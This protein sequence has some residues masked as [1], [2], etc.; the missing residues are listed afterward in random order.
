MAAAAGVTV[1]KSSL[2]RPGSDFTLSDEHSVRLRAHTPADM[3][4]NYIVT[5]S[6]TQLQRGPELAFR[7]GVGLLLACGGVTDRLGREGALFGSGESARDDG[8]VGL[9]LL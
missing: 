6:A 9:R 2:P 7:R 1:G 4:G 5:P 3:V 8:G